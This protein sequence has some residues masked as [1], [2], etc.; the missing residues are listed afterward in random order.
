MRMGYDGVEHF[1][2]GIFGDGLEGNFWEEELPPCIQSQLECLWHF[3]PVRDYSNAK[4]MLAA[5]GFTPLNVERM[6]SKSNA[7]GVSKNCVAWKVE[8]AV[9]YIVQS[10]QFLSTYLFLDPRALATYDITPISSSLAFCGY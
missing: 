10:L 5:T 3:V 8:K 9:H 4:R 2:E 1:R 6:T 7:S